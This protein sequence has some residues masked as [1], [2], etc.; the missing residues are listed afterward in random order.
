MTEPAPAPPVQTR[1]PL[2]IRVLLVM[3]LAIN[4]LIAG[5]VI[6]AVT[7]RGGDGSPRTTVGA[8][9]DLGPLPFVMAL[10]PSDRRALGGALRSEA[11]S[12]RQNREAL[13]VRF[14][15]LLGALRA[16]E[17]DRETVRRLLAEQRTLGVRRQEIGERI[18]LDRREEMSAEERRGYADRLDRSLRRTQR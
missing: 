9:R 8:A 12:L 7:S 14:E 1:T 4:L 15:A 3:S 6:G 13:R 16:E 18:L 5:I 17:F 11:S 2:W 10:E